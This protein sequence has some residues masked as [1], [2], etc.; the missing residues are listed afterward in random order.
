ELVTVSGVR[1]R[2]E[3]NRLGEKQWMMGVLIEQ[4]STLHPTPWQQFVSVID[5]TYLTLR[6]LFNRANPIGPGNMSGPVGIVHAMTRSFF[7]IFM[8]GINLVVVINFSLAI[9]SLLP[10]PVLAGGPVVYGLMESVMQRRVPSRV[11]ISL[12]SVFAV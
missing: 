10:V 6:S 8:L 4:L 7:V 1:P 12:Q 5:K 3:T 11:A 9:F 2:L